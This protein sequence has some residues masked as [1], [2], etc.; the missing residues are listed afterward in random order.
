[1]SWL[2]RTETGEAARRKETGTEARGREREEEADLPPSPLSPAALAFAFAA[3]LPYLEVPRA[4]SRGGATGAAAERRAGLGGSRVRRHALLSSISVLS[5]GGRAEWMMAG[6]L[7]PALPAGGACGL[8]P[9]HQQAPQLP[10]AALT[11]MV[12]RPHARWLQSVAAPAR[13]SLAKESQNHWPLLVC[14]FSYIVGGPERCR[15]YSVVPV[16]AA[17]ASFAFSSSISFTRRSTSSD[18]S[19]CGQRRGER[20]VELRRAQNRARPRRTATLHGQPRACLTSSLPPRR[21]TA[22]SMFLLPDCT[23]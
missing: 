12:R 8:L 13:V 19:C 16:A 2:R 22:S 10:A 4:H 9:K 17:G 15:L 14:C 1:M 18:S 23:T 3:C 7:R 6:A 21:I 5:L 11:H 20:N